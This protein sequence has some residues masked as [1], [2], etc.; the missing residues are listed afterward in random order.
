MWCLRLIYYCVFLLLSYPSLVIGQDYKRLALLIGCGEYSESSGWTKLNTA[1]DLEIVKN[2]LM[3]QGFPEGNIYSLQD[4][5]ATQAGII[6]AIRDKL[7]SNT[8]PGDIVFFQFS[9][10]GQQVRD[11]NGDEID[12]YDE[13]IVPYDSPMTFV[14]NE[15]EGDKLIRDDALAD[16]FRELRQ[17]LGKTGHLLVLMD[18]C[19]SGTGTR[20]INTSRGTDAIMAETAYIEAHQDQAKDINTFANEAFANYDDL[21]PMVSFF[22]CSPQETSWEYPDEDGNI[23]G[24]MS[25]AFSKSFSDINPD[26]TY[27]GLLDKI[28]FFVT[29][30][31]QSQTPQA[32]GD[33]DR[34]LLDGK[35]LG[36]PAYF[37]VQEILDSGI[38]KLNGGQLNGLN[39]GSVVAFFP[40][41][42]RDTTKIE[43]LAHGTVKYA[44]L[45]D[46]IIQIDHS[47]SEEKITNSWVYLRK[48]SYG[49]LKTTLQINL[50]KGL[51]KEEIINSLPG[52]PYIDLVYTEGRL[53]LGLNTTEDSVK[54]ITKDEQILFQLHINQKS[55]IVI[56]KLQKSTEEW[57][58]ANFLRN[59]EVED[60]NLKSAVTFVNSDTEEAYGN[61]DNKT[62][63]KVGDNVRV[64]VENIGLKPSYFCIVDI[65]PDNQ[66]NSL[67]GDRPSIE[68]FLYPKE[69]WISSP[70]KISPPLGREIL[71]IFTTQHPLELSNV[72]ESRGIS[73]KD[74]DNLDHPLEIFLLKNSLNGSSNR[75]ESM[76]IP[77]GTISIGSL[78]AWIVE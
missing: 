71:K 68:Y 59:L 1:G 15:Y 2:A 73:L 63:L 21:A 56:Y 43:A 24:L 16:L 20:G 49:S 25:Y 51:L 41:D 74:I 22:S 36:K 52:A 35:I 33:L 17:K 62:I 26:A 64:K 40:A 77:I 34:R 32:E 45:L 18:A 47:L 4:K 65:Q 61:Y 38:C 7:L 39:V 12:G 67:T 58:R 54:L 70:F 27:R 23:Y 31:H 50:P 69:N 8:N 9:G 78:V 10:H 5:E 42:F 55:D 48:K 44:N 72:I 6:S 3:I 37:K 53:V 29:N 46:C 60:G 11:D 75:G 28:Q 19:H 30:E 13:A 57:L 14:K 76:S 66:L